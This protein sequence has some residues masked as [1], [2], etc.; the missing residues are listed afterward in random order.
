GNLA[1][2]GG[3]PEYHGVNATDSRFKIDG[4]DYN[5]LQGAGGGS[6]R[7][8]H[9]NTMASSEVNMGLGAQSAEYETSGVQTNLV[10]HEG[11]N[12]FAITE[13]ATYSNSHFQNNNLSSELQ[14][15]G[16]TNTGGIDR[17]WDYGLAI[18]GPIRRDKVWFFFSPRWWGSDNKLPG[19]Y[20]NATQHT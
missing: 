15:R 7:L 17:I 6:A 1:W 11:A 14:A 18:G 19:T 8:Y 20:Y 13:N 16:L 2:L 5:S 9:P 10:P 3:A 4:M 12:R